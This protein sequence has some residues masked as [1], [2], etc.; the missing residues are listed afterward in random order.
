[1][2]F[3]HLIITI[4]FFQIINSQ[5]QN[6]GDIKN[7]VSKVLNEKRE[8]KV[9]LPTDYSKENKYPVVYITDANYNFEIA[10]SYLTQLIKF[11][12][13]PKTILVGIPQKDRGNELDIFWSKN[14]IRFKNFIFNE[15]I[16]LINS[17]YATSGF[18]TIIGHSDGAEYNHLLMMEKDNPFRGFINIS[19][20]LYNDV[21]NNISTYFK[22]YK[23]EK[24]YYFIANAE[25]DT[26]DRIDAGKSIEK[27]FLK[28]KNERIKFIKKNL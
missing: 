28:S 10:S 11:N 1:M 19:E 17:E 8:I 3:K 24:L 9:L 6:S 22:D 5:T 14:G 12:S 23:G 4:L 7:I 18:N 25:Y 2:S 26:Q 15:V 20:N 21:S 16:P 27:L 13:I